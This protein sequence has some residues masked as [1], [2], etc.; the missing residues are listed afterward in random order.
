MVFVHLS[1]IHFGQEKG[2]K[3]WIHE[4]VKNRLIEDVNLVAK[5]LESG[6]AAGIIVTGDIAYGGRE[7]EYA[8]AAIWLDKVAKAA[9]CAI[10]EIQVVPGNHDVN[11]DQITEATKMMLER[12]VDEGEDALD[13]FL[14]SD[15]DRA[16]LFGRFSAYRPFAEGYRCPLDTKAELPEQ[17]VAQLALGRSIRF[18]V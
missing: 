13:K 9:G 17:H 6:C 8:E 11:R 4:D 15:A 14:E 1:D 2:G 18:I 3:I 5:C 16:L 10:S 7:S 12:I